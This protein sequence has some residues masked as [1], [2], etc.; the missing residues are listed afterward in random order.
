MRVLLAPDRLSG[1][2]TAAAVAD[3]LATGW[4]HEAAAGEVRRLAMSD[5]AH[6]MIETVHDALGGQ[7]LPLTLHDTLGTFLPHRARPVGEMPASV[8]HVP[9]AHG[10]T[11]YVAGEQALAPT[12]VPAGE[13]LE[14]AR[15]ATSEGLGRLLGAALG[16]G[17]SRIVLGLGP[18][19]GH[20]AGTGLLAHL[21]RAL[22]GAGDEAVP[23]ALRGGGLGLAA[24]APDDLALL[25]EVRAALTDRDLVLA[26]GDDRPLLG[27]HGSGAGLAERPGIDPGAAQEIDRAVGHA[28]ALL[29]PHL[30]APHRTDLLRTV[31]TG[32]APG[33]H[34]RRPPRAG[35]ADGSGA[36]GGAALMLEALGAR[37]LPG[38]RALAHLLDL[39]GRLETCDVVVTTCA[40]LDS[41]SLHSAVVGTVAELAAAEALPVV[42]LAEEVR[43]SRRELAAAGV[44]AAYES[45]PLPSLALP[46]L[47]EWGSRLARTWARR[48]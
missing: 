16:T 12:H 19:A 48:T 47:E 22:L 24:L 44:V 38:A 43:A 14:A 45:G 17:A 34:D 40:V 7:L 2:L 26:V 33:H 1:N 32:E 41:R 42:V 27:L 29:E 15:H 9:G 4:Q 21:L 35:R 25:P 8:L 5:G 3:A 20:D 30:A 23:E 10:G 28:C 36:S 31:G 46:A 13:A 37:A 39:P 6:D 18:A 11:A